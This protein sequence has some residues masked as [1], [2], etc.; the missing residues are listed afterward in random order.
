MQ[1]G[2]YFVSASSDKFCVLFMRKP[3]GQHR[4]LHSNGTP[5]FFYYVFQFGFNKITE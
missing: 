1:F 5:V 3:H 4:F 2:I